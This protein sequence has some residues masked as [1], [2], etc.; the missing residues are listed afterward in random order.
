MDSNLGVATIE[1]VA[2]LAGVSVSTV[3]RTINDKPD[4]AESTKRR[5]LEAMDKLGYTPHRYASNLAGGLS[6]TVGLLLPI[7]EGGMRQLILDFILGASR[8]LEE[9]DFL[10]NVI[11]K[12]LQPAELRTLKPRSQLDGV[13]LMRTRLADPRVD[14]LSSTELPFVLLGRC[15]S[16]DGLSYVDLD[17][18]SAIEQSVDYLRAL[19][20][21]HF[22][23]LS[24]DESHKAE[25]YTF[26]HLT[27][28]AFLAICKKYGLHGSIVPCMPTGDSVARGT[29]RLIRNNPKI[30]AVLTVYG[31]LAPV[32]EKVLE[33]LDRP[34]P[35]AVSLLAITEDKTAERLAPALTSVTF[36]SE[37]MGFQAATLLVDEV[38]S[39]GQRIAPRQV[40]LKPTLTV[41]ETTG[42]PH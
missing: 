28:S 4:V 6:R 5:I 16:N 9:R 32:A 14:A 42:P 22:G 27:E 8:A 20:H 29:R 11:T 1:E 2:K 34:V 7:R 18:D 23:L 17:F 38:L 24:Y 21:R 31:E 40:L 10:L 36:P 35:D 25:G 12:E 3:S 26:V 19:G 33:E 41:R 30:S 15:R 39:R 13:I 37:E